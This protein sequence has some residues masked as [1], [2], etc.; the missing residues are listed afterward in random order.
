MRLAW[1]VAPVRAR[2][3]ALQLHEAQIT[4]ESGQALSGDVESEES[5]AEAQ[6]GFDGAAVEFEVAEP[7]GGEARGPGSRAF[8][9]R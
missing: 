3:R 7:D 1:R 9:R 4:A 8:E 5:F 6:A 2:A